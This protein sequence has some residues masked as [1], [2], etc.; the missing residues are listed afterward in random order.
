M[1]NYEWPTY[2]SHYYP[3]SVKFE[4]CCAFPCVTQHL[5]II[6]RIPTAWM[7]NLSVVFWHM[8]ENI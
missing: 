4:I 3:H 6:Y 5:F 7:A 8:T 1:Q 2:S